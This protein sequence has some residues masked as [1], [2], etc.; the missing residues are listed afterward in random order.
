MLH[1]RCYPKVPKEGFSQNSQKKDFQDA[2]KSW[3]NVGLDVFALK[4]YFED[5]E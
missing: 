4:D 3:Q 1:T 2:F 5:D